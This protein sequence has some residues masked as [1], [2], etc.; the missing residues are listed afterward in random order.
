MD[1]GENPALQRRRLR[2]T[3]RQKRLAADLTQEEVAEKLYWS[4][5]KV[6][7]IENG[8]SS[9]SI[10]DLQAMLRLYHIQQPEEIDALVAL[11]RYGRRPS[12]IDR[13][14]DVLSA[15]FRTYL[16]HEASAVRVLQYETEL[17]PGMLQTAEYAHS[18]I[19]M[20]VPGIADHV[21][22][23]LVEARVQRQQLLESPPHP[24][25]VVVLDESIMRRRIGGLTGSPG[26]FADQL[27]RL[28]DL[29]RRDRVSIR[30]LPFGAGE[31]PGMSTGSFTILGFGSPED[32][33]VLYQELPAGSDVVERS[34]NDLPRYLEVFDRLRDMSLSSAE[35]A[36]L[37]AD[38]IS[39]ED[40]EPQARPPPER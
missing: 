38:R 16:D 6:L 2:R 13:Y 30:V 33:D 22:G 18:T 12:P 9:L 40:P 37:I 32:D 36:A 7:R 19:R 15:E 35:S 11:A 3:L 39:E 25:M 14:K 24:E 5:S 31:H 1:G 21:L 17:I 26:L 23:R 27:R 20:L 8:Q 34:P 4:K 10:T 28:R 29:N